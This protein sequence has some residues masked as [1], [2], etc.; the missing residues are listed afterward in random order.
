MEVQNRLRLFHE[1]RM[2]KAL[3]PRLQDVKLQRKQVKEKWDIMMKLGT[4]QEGGTIK[5]S[6][7]T[8]ED[9]EKMEKEKQQV[10]DEALVESLR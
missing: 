2:R 6:E 5:Q 7:N 9:I 3:E 10:E 8:L 1:D 4:P